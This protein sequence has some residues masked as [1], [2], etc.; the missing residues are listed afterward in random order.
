MAPSEL[1]E[2]DAMSPMA[3]LD[4]LHLA[5]MND[6]G[7]A[8]SAL[9]RVAERGEKSTRPINQTLPSSIFNI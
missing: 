3:A 6:G 2:L 5:V 1:M 7:S 8:T 9:P 4:H